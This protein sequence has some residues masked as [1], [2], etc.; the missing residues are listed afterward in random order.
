MIECVVRFAMGGVQV[1]MFSNGS[2]LISPVFP[3][4]EE[5]TAWADEERSAW[6][7]DSS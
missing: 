6:E 1:E 4:G 3:N 2:A 7:R 5:A